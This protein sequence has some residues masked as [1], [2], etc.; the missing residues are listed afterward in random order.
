MIYAG[1]GHRPNKLGGYSA[2]LDLALTKFARRQ[3]IQTKPTGVISGMALGWDQ[4][5]AVAAVQT[6]IGFVAAIP[7]HGQEKRWPAASQR[8]Y[9]RLLS[10]ASMVYAV[11]SPEQVGDA[12]VSWA[13]QERNCWMVDNSQGVI[14]LWNGE[15]SGGTYNCV[16]YAKAG[17]RQIVNVWPAWEEWWEYGG[18]LV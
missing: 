1:T 5:L 8:A 17:K 15:R 2:E 14:A 11:C 3:L 10:A 4:A 6:G 13:M 7:F 9:E 16:Q 18:Y 12:G